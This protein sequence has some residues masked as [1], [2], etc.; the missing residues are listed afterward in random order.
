[1][2]QIQVAVVVRLLLELLA[3][4]LQQ[5]VQAAMERHLVFQGLL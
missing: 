3:M 1:M 4:R 2:V 5:L